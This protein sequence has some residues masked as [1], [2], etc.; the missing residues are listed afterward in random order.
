MTDTKRKA[1][2]HEGGLAKG[3]LTCFA[4]TFVGKQTFVL[5][6]NI[7]AKK[8]RPSPSRKTLAAICSFITTIY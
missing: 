4:G 6:M 5:R 2:G 7:R 8:S 1:R 3:G